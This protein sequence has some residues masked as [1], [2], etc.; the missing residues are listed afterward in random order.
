GGIV[1]LEVIAQSSQQRGGSAS[2]RLAMWKHSLYCFAAITLLAVRP[3]V[4]AASN[5]IYISSASPGNSRQG[6]KVDGIREIDL[7][8]IA[9]EG[10]FLRAW[11]R[12]TYSDDVADVPGQKF[13]RTSRQLYYF[14]CKTRR[15]SLAQLTTYDAAGN[16]LDNLSVAPWSAEFSLVVV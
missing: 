8:S 2:K 4:G 13:Y 12:D 15:S 14:D 11:F 1:T 16:S 5:W 9:A 6:A 10:P 7:Q 3:E